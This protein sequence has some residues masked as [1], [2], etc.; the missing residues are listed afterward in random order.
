M[1]SGL[2]VVSSTW[3]LTV[4]A[5][6][7]KPLSDEHASDFHNSMPLFLSK[8]RIL[9]RFLSQGL[10]QFFQCMRTVARATPFWYFVPWT[11]HQFALK[12][13]NCYQYIYIIINDTTESGALQEQ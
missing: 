5:P 7:F 8:Q 2:K 4:M 12:S 1:C 13:T 11:I 9:A 10:S 3:L 6:S